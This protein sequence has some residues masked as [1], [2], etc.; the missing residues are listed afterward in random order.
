MVRRPFVVLAAALVVLAPARADPPAAPLPAVFDV[1]A[2][3]AYVARQVREKGYVGLSLAVVRD[4]RLVLAKGYGAAA[5]DGPAVQTDTPF[6]IGSVTK[7][8]TCAC[9]F[10]LA[11]EGKLSVRDPVAKYYPDLT[12]AGDVTLYDLMSHASGYPDYY[13][14]DFVDRRMHKPIAA[15]DLIREYA[16]GKLDFAPGSRWSY[17]NTGYIIL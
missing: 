6:A 7:Q 8:F 11:E 12:R 16:G 17:S 1:P 5:L 9:V 3:D 15:D 2:V 4:G 10:L 13:P 14:L